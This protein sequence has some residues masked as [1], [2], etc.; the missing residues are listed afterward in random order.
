MTSQGIE[1]VFLETRN[2]GA[3]G[4]FLRE[5]GFTVDFETDHNSGQFSNGAGPYVFV[6]EV[7][8]DHEPRTRLV[9]KVQDTARRPGDGVDIVS[10]FE[11]THYG[12][13]EMTV[14]DPD[15]RPWIL[16]APGKE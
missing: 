7:P 15:G 16:Q 14:N 2:W 5:L 3:T 1:A 11:Q 10:E 4:R 8:P 9:L 13:Q 12:T 6:V